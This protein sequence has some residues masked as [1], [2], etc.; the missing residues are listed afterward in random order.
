MSERTGITRRRAI[1]SIGAVGIAALG[2]D[3]LAT[4]TI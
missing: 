1:A 2:R 4:A 3:R